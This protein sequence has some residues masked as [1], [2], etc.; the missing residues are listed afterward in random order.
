MSSRARRSSLIPNVKDRDLPIIDIM[1]S[2]GIAT[3][4]SISP[5]HSDLVIPPL[6]FSIVEDKLYRGSYPRPL[7]FKFLESLN[8]CTILSLTPEPLTEDAAGWCRAR[9]ISMIHIRPERDGKKGAPLKH[10]EACKILSVRFLVPP[11]RPYISNIHGGEDNAEQHLRTSLRT[12][13]QW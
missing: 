9:G 13:S 5:D 2:T 7:N 3:I 4:T 12:L 1:T 6:R 11:R 10:A 8:L